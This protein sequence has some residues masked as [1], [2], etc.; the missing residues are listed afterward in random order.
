MSDLR[1]PRKFPRLAAQRLAEHGSGAAPASF[2][3]EG[4]IV[5]SRGWSGAPAW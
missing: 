5:K 1:R 2:E 3:P 4:L